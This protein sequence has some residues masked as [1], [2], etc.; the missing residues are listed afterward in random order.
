M[1]P[2]KRFQVS[3][4]L[5]PEFFATFAHATCSLSELH[6]YLALEGIYLQLWYVL[7]NIPTLRKGHEMFANRNT[8]LSPSVVVHSSSTSP[9]ANT[10]E[11]LSKR[12]NSRTPEASPIQHELLPFHSQLL[13]ES[14]LFSFPPLIDMLKFSGFSHLSRDSIERKLYSTRWTWD[15]IPGAVCVQEVKCFTEF[16]NSHY[17]S[18]LAALFIGVQSESSTPYSISEATPPQ[19]LQVKF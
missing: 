4:T 6:P 19:G 2:C 16:C 1:L 10:P 13:R 5:S 11:P 17:L 18:Q 9:R 12:Y 7:S 3:L 15:G 14:Q 8:G